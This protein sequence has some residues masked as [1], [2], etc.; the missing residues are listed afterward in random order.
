[1]F[2]ELIIF[3]R[4]FLTFNVNVRNILQNSVSPH[5]IVTNPNNVMCG[6][7]LVTYSNVSLFY[8][9][10]QNNALEHQPHGCQVHGTPQL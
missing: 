7:L 4:M 2:C 1:M 6:P 9:T 10:I 5:N 3:Y 8:E